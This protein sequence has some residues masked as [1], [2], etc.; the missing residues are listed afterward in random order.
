[1]M[2]LDAV[3][4]I[5]QEKWGAFLLYVFGTNS[6]CIV[7]CWLGI[8]HRS[9]LGA[10]VDCFEM[11]HFLVGLNPCFSDSS[12]ISADRVIFG[13][14]LTAGYTLPI[15]NA[16]PALVQERMGSENIR[17]INAGVSGDTSYIIESVADGTG[18]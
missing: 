1:M 5:Q 8:L 12:R 15:H 10:G 6:M 16:Y 11:A 3:K 13:D 4:L 2:A 18:Q 7:G 17:V 9:L 14:S